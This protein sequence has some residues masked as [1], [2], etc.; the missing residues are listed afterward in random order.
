M[1][2]PPVGRKPPPRRK[3]EFSKAETAA[4]VGELRRYFVEE[5]D[6]EIGQLPAEMMVEFIAEK[7]GV[8]FYNRGLY[9]AQQLLNERMADVSD[10]MLALEF[11]TGTGR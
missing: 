1:S 3:I 2:R 4:M 5:L 7:L 6:G 8:Y 11:P 9:D 10:Q